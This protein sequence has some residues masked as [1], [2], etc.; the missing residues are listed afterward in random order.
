MIFIK[1]SFPL[2]LLIYLLKVSVTSLLDDLEGKA[3]KGS[4]GKMH[5]TESATGHAKNAR[6]FKISKFWKKIFI[7]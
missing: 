5:H 4:R 2:K 7:D 6:T 3:E 1:F